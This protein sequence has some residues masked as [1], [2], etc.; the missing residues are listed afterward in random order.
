MVTVKVS[1]LNHAKRGCWVENIVPD[2]DGV[3]AD[4]VWDLVR[5]AVREALGC[6]LGRQPSM[7]TSVVLWMSPPCRTFSKTD[8]SNRNRKDSKGRGCGYRDH[9]DDL[10]PP[11]DRHSAKG[12][13]AVA[14]DKLVQLWMQVALLWEVKMP[15][16]Y[17]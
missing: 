1:T 13:M 15:D 2:L 8:A 9:K 7:A 4:R 11:L 12:K 16:Y 17:Y 3:R 10:R 5:T 6:D 14:T